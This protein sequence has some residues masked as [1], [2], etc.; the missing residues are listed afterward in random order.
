M[1]GGKKSVL[2]AREAAL[3]TLN[4]FSTDGAYLN[5]V[6]PKVTGGLPPKERAL[7]QK[8]ARGTVERLNTL[9]WALNQFSN[10]K[11]ENINPALLNLLRL[12]A[13]QLLYLQRVP[14][15]AAV[16]EAVSLALR[17]GHKKAAGF[18][19]AVLRRLGR[20]KDHLPWP[21]AQQNP[22]LYLV[23]Q[24]SLPAWL[25]KRALK[26]F[27]FAEAEAWA[28]AVNIKPATALRPNP[29][30]I[31]PGTLAVLLEK[32]GTAVVPS[33]AVPGMLRLAAGGFNCR[34]S[35]AFQKGY[36]TVQGE[37]SGLPALLLELQAGATVVDLCAAPG[38]KTT[39]IVELLQDRGLVYAVELHP[40]RLQLITKAADRL[41]LSI[42]QPVAGDG[43]K[44]RS[45]SLGRPEAVLV[46][47]PCSGLG[48]TGRLPEIKW[49]RGLKDLPLLQK[50]QLALLEAAAS[51]LA[52]CGRLVYAVCSTEPEETIEV[53]RLFNE[54]HPEFRQETI[55][56]KLPAALA[57]KSAC[58]APGYIWPHRHGLDG[59]FMALWR[60]R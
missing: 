58:A 15:Y 27:G 3:I 36:Y 7:A 50:E 52:P 12:S 49:R 30:R 16:D 60:K 32:E 28:K 57:E 41:G 20:E 24:Y 44:A 10:T 45:L 51:L 21:Q 8:L 33:P 38:G 2:G 37:S 59:F 13:Y 48:V 17:L 31:S 42:I 43:K 25:A 53:A 26:R 5:L 39:Q 35:E 9:D 4:R 18:V 46:D 56:Q 23:L 47:A 55:E 34:R 54:G 22:L 1:P 14:A 6:L 19:N 29:L 40:A 11:T